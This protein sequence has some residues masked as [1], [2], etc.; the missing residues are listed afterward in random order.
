MSQL[1]D[2]K[3]W[4]ARHQDYSAEN[5]A[6]SVRSERGV[7]GRL[8]RLRARVG[9]QPSE[10]Y[11][12][13]QTAR[14]MK[15][16]LPVRSD[17]SV[18][19]V[20]CAPGR[21]LL[22]MRE[23]FGYVPF[24]IEYSPVG[25]AETRGVFARNGIDPAN[26]HEGD[27]FAPAVQQGLAG[28]FDVV[29]SRGFVEHFPEPRGVIAQHVNLLKPGGYLV[30]TIPNLRSFAWPFLATCARDILN[31]HNTRIMRRRV[32][33]ELFE[34]QGLESL[35]CQYVGVFQFFGLVLRHEH[36]PRGWVARGMD[37]LSD[38]INHAL[39]AALR[40]RAIEHAWSPHLIYIGRR[41]G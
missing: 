23:L 24:G 40:G 11:A 26:V 12:D 30:C 41:Q 34:H 38:V 19:E 16:H 5:A 18:V 20:G 27:F 15:R 9:A 39:F 37:R 2:R 33:G 14:V 32:Y 35:C 31:A 8:A 4:D 28:R 17:W 13:F 22:R 10:S 7:R 21:H 3:F 6:A 29:L 25:A 1:V 36:S